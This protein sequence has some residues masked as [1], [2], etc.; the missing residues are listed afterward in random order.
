MDDTE[1]PLKGVVRTVR[2]LR[3]LFDKIEASYTE[4]D[5]KFFGDFEGTGLYIAYF[6]QH[7]NFLGYG[8]PAIVENNLG[9][10]FGSPDDLY[11]DSEENHE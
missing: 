6:D 5:K 7:Q 4:D 10:V 11:V 2:D 8:Y 3:Q 1:N 9:I